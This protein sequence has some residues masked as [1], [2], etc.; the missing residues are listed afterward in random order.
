MRTKYFI[1]GLQIYLVYSEYN[2]ILYTE[3]RREIPEG[4]K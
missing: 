2:I 1:V 4:K 3:V